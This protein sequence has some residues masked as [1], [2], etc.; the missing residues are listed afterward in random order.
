MATPCN[1]TTTTC[2]VVQLQLYSHFVF[3]ISYFSLTWKSF[4]AK[5]L[6]HPSRLRIWNIQISNYQIIKAQQQRDRLIVFLQHPSHYHSRF[7]CITHYFSENPSWFYELLQY[8]TTLL[9]AF[10]LQHEITNFKELKRNIRSHKSDLDTKSAN[11]QNRLALFVPLRE[12][13]CSIKGNSM[14]P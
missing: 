6:S 7:F 2:L 11:L 1:R 10:L 14:F 8:R 5:H 9:Y 4:L 12:N 3:F 13:L